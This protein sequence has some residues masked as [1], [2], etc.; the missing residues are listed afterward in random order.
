MEMYFQLLF[1]LAYVTIISCQNYYNDINKRNNE[2]YYLTTNYTID[3]VRNIQPQKC[4]TNNECPHYSNGCYISLEI[5]KNKNITQEEKNQISKEYLIKNNIYGICLYSYYCTEN[6][7]KTISN[8]NCIVEYWSNYTNNDF[9]SYTDIDN[10]LKGNPLK[11]EF[12][13]SA[14]TE[15]GHINKIV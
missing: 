6:I 5:S 1:F 8:N 12:S 14:I 15:Y 11:Q 7:N 9:L 3:F 13:E 2:P 4:Y 10:R